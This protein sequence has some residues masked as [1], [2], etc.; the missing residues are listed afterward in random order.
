V[1]ISTD[2][3][4]QTA[5]GLSLEALLESPDAPGGAFV[6]CHPHPQ[7]GGTM[8]APLLNAITA[9]LLER[10][11]AVLR[12]NFRGIGDSQGESSTGIGE[13]ADAEAAVA[14]A[15]SRCPDLPVAIGGWSFGAAVAGR[16]AAK[17]ADLAAY[18]AIAPAVS[19]KPGITA[20]LPP[21]DDLHLAMPA[22]VIVGVNDELV[23]PSEARAWAEGVG[24][25]LVEMKGANHFFWAKYDNLTKVVCDFLDQVL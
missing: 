5:D 23:D 2:L 7:M 6:F 25:Q 15:H 13:I 17:D 9:G 18:V 1:T 19:E 4:L 8:K 12:F 21:P 22:L 3:R 11:W 14:E 20:G 24:A 10:G 16:V